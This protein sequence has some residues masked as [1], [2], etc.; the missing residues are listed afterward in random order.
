MTGGG[1]ELHNNTANTVIDSYPGDDTGAVSTTEWWVDV[2]IA[3]A[4]GTGTEFDYAVFVVCAPG[5]GTTTASTTRMQTTDST[6]LLH[7][8]P[9]TAKK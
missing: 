1:A 3:V 9:L 2:H 5:T 6:H 4:N 8:L 7:A